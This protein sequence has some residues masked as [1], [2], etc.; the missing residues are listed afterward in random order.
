MKE[1]IVGGKTLKVKFTQDVRKVTMQVLEQNESLRGKGVIV[2]SENGY[3]ISSVLH[4]EI[5]AETGTLYVRGITKAKD[6]KVEIN[7]FPAYGMAM[8]YIKNISELI[9]KIND[10]AERKDTG[11]NESIII[12]TDGFKVTTAT[13]YGKDGK[14]IKKAE[15]KCSPEDTFNFKIGVK[16]AIRRLFT[17]EMI[18]GDE[19]LKIKFEQC[20]NEV[21]AKIINQ[22]ESLRGSG[23]ICEGDNYGIIRYT[24]NRRRGG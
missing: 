24:E 17:E 1:T 18:V 23:T 14:Q 15:A 10:K 3:S 19:V 16:E 2:Q 6:D 8:A 22:D 21:T 7:L 11:M 12:R 20:G 5:N 4:P 9:Q 13:L